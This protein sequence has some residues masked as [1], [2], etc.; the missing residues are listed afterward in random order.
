MTNPVILFGTQANGET[1]PVQ[2]DATGRLVAEGLQGSKGEDGAQGPKGDTGPPGPPGELDLPPDPYEGALLGWLNNQL[3]WIGSPPVPVPEGLFGPI[4]SYEDGVVTI[5]GSVPEQVGP[6]VYLSQVNID[7]SNYCQDWNN[8]E[9]WSNTS[10]G[11]LRQPFDGNPATWIGMEPDTLYFLPASVPVTS[12]IQAAFIANTGGW[13]VSAYTTNGKAGPW[14]QSQGTN[15]VDLFL[16]SGT[17]EAFKCQH[18]DGQTWVGPALLKVDGLTLVDSNIPFRARVSNVLSDNQI[19]VVP[20]GNIPLTPGK[21]LK[22][23]QQRVSP[24]VYYKNSRW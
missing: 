19:L 3:A 21:Y 12:K 17:F 13:Q 14:I 22:I 18:N 2:V 8:S 9:I 15:L 20:D 11:Y 23:P 6:G 24:A 10:K 5:E 7:E 4:I 16:G 1:L